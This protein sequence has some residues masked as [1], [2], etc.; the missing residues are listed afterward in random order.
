MQ[1]GAEAAPV[2]LCPVAPCSGLSAKG[3]P[4]GF[5]N[6]QAHHHDENHAHKARAVAQGHPGA[7]HTAQHVGDG[8]RHG[9]VPPDMAFERKQ[10]NR[11][12]VGVTFISLA[13]MEAFK[14]S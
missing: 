4:P 8:Q 1:K 11:S 10:G 9:K 14:K 2:A 7:Q 3:I 5:E 13:L 6:Q 12:D